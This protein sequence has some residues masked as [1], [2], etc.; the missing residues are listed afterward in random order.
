MMC[1]KVPLAV[2]SVCN[3][4]HKEKAESVNPSCCCSAVSDSFVTLW[5]VAHQSPLSMG[6]PRQEYW[7]GFPFPSPRDLS[8]PGNEHTSPALA[9]EFFTA[10]PPGKLHPIISAANHRGGTMVCMRERCYYSSLRSPSYLRFC[11]THGDLENM[12]E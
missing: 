9:G 10:E 3:D 12:N 11:L 8:D 6:F 2:S 1:M 4:G 5:T 7:S